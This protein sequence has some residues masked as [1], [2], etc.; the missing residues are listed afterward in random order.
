MSPIRLVAAS[1]AMAV[2]VD[3]TSGD[4]EPD[5]LQVLAGVVWVLGLLA[6]GGLGGGWSL[7]AFSAPFCLVALVHEKYFY[8]P[9]RFGC[10]PICGSP[11][12][13]I[14]YVLPFLL[15]LLACGWAGGAFVRRRSR[16]R[17]AF[18]T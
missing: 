5:A 9:P 13:G 6:L 15:V 14:P 1:A 18:R 7:I 3:L 16:R 17:V 10:D 11:A 8:D 12:E 2:F 4:V